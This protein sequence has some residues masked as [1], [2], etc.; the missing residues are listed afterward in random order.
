LHLGDRAFFPARGGEG[1]VDLAEGLA[2]FVGQHY[3]DH[4][5]PP[6]LV[7]GLDISEDCGAALGAKNVAIALPRNEMERAWFAMAEKNAELAI[8]SRRHSKVRAG[9]RLLALQEALELAEPPNRIECF[10][11]SHTMG[12]GTV[13]SC[14]VC[15]EG[16]MKKGDYRRFN[17]AGI[18]PG[19]DYAAMRQALTRRYEKVAAGDAVAPDLILIDGGK[20]QHRV[21]REVLTDLGLGHLLSV[22]IAKG[23]ERKPGLEILF[24]HDR[25]EPLQLAPDH[26][27][28]HLIQE[29]RD[30]AH[31]FAI[32]G[33]R[34]RRAKARGRSKLEDVPGI[35]AARRRSLL[36]H[37][38]GLDGVVAATVEDLCRAGGISRRLAEAIYQHLHNR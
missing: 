5:P 8:E 22:G 34:A 24:V 30:E 12:E 23:E 38:G 6:R 20:G 10:D 1:D 26:T 32:A 11:I 19:D 13:A 17:I 14:V 29:I 35:G 21:A 37:F 25:D 3:L 33:H 9:S 18:E 36:A 31:R 16:A 28:F 7:V 27:G 4:P 15:A 2:A